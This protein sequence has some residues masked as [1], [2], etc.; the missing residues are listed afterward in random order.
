MPN[1]KGLFFSEFIFFNPDLLKAG[2][3]ENK[4][5]YLLHATG[6]GKGCRISN[7]P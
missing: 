1:F 6:W 2:K 3:L 4:K 7:S 5:F